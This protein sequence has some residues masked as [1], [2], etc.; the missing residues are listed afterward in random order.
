MAGVSVQLVQSWAR[1][2][3]I[4]WRKARQAY[5]AAEW[6]ELVLGERPPIRKARLRKIAARAKAKW[7]NDHGRDTQD[8]DQA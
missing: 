6:R 4:D 2:S 1:S 8:S 7:D 3:G 5:L